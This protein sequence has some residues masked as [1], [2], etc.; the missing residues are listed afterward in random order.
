MMNLL[1]FKGRLLTVENTEIIK[2]LTLGQTIVSISN[3]RYWMKIIINNNFVLIYK[4]KLK[5]ER[6]STCREQGSSSR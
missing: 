3:R 6:C 1:I 5:C 2:L 4:I